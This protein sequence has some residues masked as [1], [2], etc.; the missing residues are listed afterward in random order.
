M[1]KLQEQFAFEKQEQYSSGVTVAVDAMMLP[2][3]WFSGFSGLLKAVGR[4]GGCHFFGVEKAT[5]A[6]ACNSESASRIASK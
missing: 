2:C 4:L 6:A 5:D 3:F 1:R